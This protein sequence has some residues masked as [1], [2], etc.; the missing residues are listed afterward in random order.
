PVKNLEWATVPGYFH[1]NQMGDDLTVAY[2]YGTG[3]P[4]RPIVFSENTASTLSP[5]ISSIK[6]FTMAV[7]PNPGL[8]R[9]PWKED[10]NTH[11]DWLVGLSHMNRRSHLT[12]T[13]Y[14]PVL[15]EGGSKMVNGQQ[16]T[17]DFRISFQD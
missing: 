16:L 15:G 17:F 7:I 12:P 11:S 14:Y 10:K 8:G 5:M 2:A 6:G 9:D 3:V 13:L 4:D 1:G